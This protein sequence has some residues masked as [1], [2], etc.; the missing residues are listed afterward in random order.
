MKY[1]TLLLVML[2]ANAHLMGQVS[3]QNIYLE[4]G[5]ASGI[6]SINYE[7]LFPLNESTFFTGRIGGMYLN[8]LRKNPK[9]YEGIPAGI[10]YLK[11]LKKNY[12]EI[13]LSVAWAQMQKKNNEADR[14]LHGENL[15]KDNQIWESLRIG[16]RHQ[17]DGKGLFWNTLLQYSTVLSKK[18][19]Q[20]REEYTTIYKFPYV[21]FGMG[22]TF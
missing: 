3:Q 14:L 9:T 22:Y 1:I 18:N 7:R 6:Y 4:I 12:L 13:G 17:P 10:S 19:V 11:R 21:S 5:G 20:S 2:L 16:I 15:F 8:D